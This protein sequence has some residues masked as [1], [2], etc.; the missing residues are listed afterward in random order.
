MS[1]LPNSRFMN[2]FEVIWPTQPAGDDRRPTRFASS[3]NRSMKGTVRAY[4]PLQVV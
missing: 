1:L 2:E 3:K 4:L